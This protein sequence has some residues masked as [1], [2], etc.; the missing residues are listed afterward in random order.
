LTTIAGAL[1][2]PIASRAIVKD[3]LNVGSYP[4]K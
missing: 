2:P 1:S 3:A 4:G